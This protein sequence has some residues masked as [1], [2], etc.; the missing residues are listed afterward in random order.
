MYQKKKKKLTNHSGL[1]LFWRDKKND[2]DFDFNDSNLNI[3]LK[4]NYA[5]VLICL[6]DDHVLFAL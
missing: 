3:L 5:F 1:C 6:F 2:L 4:P